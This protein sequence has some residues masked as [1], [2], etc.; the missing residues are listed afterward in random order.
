MSTPTNTL[1]SFFVA[2]Y[3]SADA[4]AAPLYYAPIN[5]NFGGNPNNG[6]FLQ[7]EATDNNHFKGHAYD[8]PQKSA[9]QAIADSITNSVLS[10][11]ANK[12]AT[13]IGNG[14]QSGSFQIGNSSISFLNQGAFT[15]LTINDG[16]GGVT[17]VS[18]PNGL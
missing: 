8:T 17:Q 13:A 16:Q 7:Q 15:L 2:A 9:T 12:V 11:V 1:L 5:P 10:Q 18:I 14:D 4:F 6:V 3:I